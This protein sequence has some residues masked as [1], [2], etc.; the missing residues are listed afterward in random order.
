LNLEEYKLGKYKLTD[1]LRKAKA[2][3]NILTILKYRKKDERDKIIS[4]ICSKSNPDKIKDIFKVLSWNQIKEMHKSKL[5]N[6]GAHTTTH[7]ILTNLN[8]RKKKKEISKSCNIIK[9]SLNKSDII[10]AY[11]NGS[12]KDFDEESIN[13]LKEINILGSLSTIEGL[14]THKENLYRLKRMSIGADISKDKF[15]ALCSGI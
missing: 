4:K 10:F 6:F 11:P 3:E 5:I 15:K 14:N 8:S 9:D 7:E 1:N 2:V 13:I 12:R